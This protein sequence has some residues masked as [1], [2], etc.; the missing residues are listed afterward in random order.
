MSFDAEVTADAPRSWWRFDDTAG[1]DVPDFGAT[2]NHGLLKAQIQRIGDTGH[3]SIRTGDRSVRLPYV[4]GNDDEDAGGY[5]EASP[6]LFGTPA[7]WT[8]EAVVAPDGPPPSDHS[9]FIV[10]NSFADGETDGF[11]MGIGAS[12]APAAAVSNA[13]SGGAGGT[14]YYEA[15]G[16]SE[17]CWVGWNHI[18]ATYAA[19]T[20][21]L[22]HQGDEVATKAV[23]GG[24]VYHPSR[25]LLVGRQV[26]EDRREDRWYD[27][28]ISEVALYNYALSAERIAAHAATAPWCQRTGILVGSVAL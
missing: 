5:M 10:T 3:R 21:R 13:S 8:L 26:K 19:G 6:A 28:R 24:L 4:E 14:G 17:V 25:R 16:S 7:A 27:G 11:L 22:Y 9:L 2:G 12:G 20:L 18:A 15:T 23:A 1:L